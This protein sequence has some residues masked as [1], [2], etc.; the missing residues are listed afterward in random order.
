MALEGGDAVRGT[1]LAGAIA[2]ARKKAYGNRYSV[3][4][5][6]RGL[7]E[8]AAAII[9]YLVANTEVSVNV[10]VAD[11]IPV[12]TPDTLTGET[13]DTGTGAGTGTIS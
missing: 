3:M 5:D 10:T 8:E 7:D 6:A 11:G 4:A 1:G 2:A 9:E 13:T 12:E